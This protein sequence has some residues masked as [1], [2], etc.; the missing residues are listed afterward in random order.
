MPHIKTSECVSESD[1]PVTSKEKTGPSE[2]RRGA[3]ASN[4]GVD[5]GDRGGK[6]DMKL[7]GLAS[8]LEEVSAPVLE[9][10]TS[11]QHNHSSEYHRCRKCNIEQV[12]I[13]NFQTRGWQPQM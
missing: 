8:A 7:E 13:N 5:G 9:C 6:Q 10:Q 11:P 2:C 3:F 1:Q 12:C 4:G